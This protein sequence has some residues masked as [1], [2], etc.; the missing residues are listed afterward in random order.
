MSKG[1]HD[2][3]ANLDRCRETATSEVTRPPVVNSMNLT[4]LLQLPGELRNQIYECVLSAG[5]NLLKH[6]V[7]NGSNPSSTGPDLFQAHY[8]EN[9]GLEFNQLKY[10][11]KQLWWETH[12]LELK[13][14]SILF[15]GLTAVDELGR[16]LT[17]CSPLQK[18]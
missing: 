12:S 8:L 14:N 2:P 6:H 16:F 10:V 15:E 4:P 11:S 1:S 13:Y 9:N 3:T 18:E 5:D 17:I 7:V